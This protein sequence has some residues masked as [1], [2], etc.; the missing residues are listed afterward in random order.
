MKKLQAGIQLF[1]EVQFDTEQLEVNMLCVSNSYTLR[2]ISL[3]DPLSRMN[4]RTCTQHVSHAYKGRQEQREAIW[5][6][7]E[8]MEAD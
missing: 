6:E 3:D 2:L 7:S 4:L 1:N 5:V 8:N